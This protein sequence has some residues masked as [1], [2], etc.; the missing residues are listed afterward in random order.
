MRRFPHFPDVFS[1]SYIFLV[2][3]MSLRIDLC[4]CERE[5]VSYNGNPKEQTSDK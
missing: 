2:L 4:M 1:T 3:I 5:I